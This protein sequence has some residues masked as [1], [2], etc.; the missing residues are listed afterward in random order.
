MKFLLLAWGSP[1]SKLAL[2]VLM[3]YIRFHYVLFSIGSLHE[4]TS[5]TKEVTMV[6]ARLNLVDGADQV[7]LFYIL[8][9]GCLVRISNKIVVTLLFMMLNLMCILD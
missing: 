7:P 4:G 8:D 9:V 2:I 5:L 3:E 1:W 6:K